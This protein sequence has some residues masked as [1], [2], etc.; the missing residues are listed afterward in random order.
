MDCALINEGIREK[1][2][3]S[4]VSNANGFTGEITFRME[5]IFE[6]DY[7]EVSGLFS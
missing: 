6:N 3:F 7:F 2:I 5:Y 1:R 4:N